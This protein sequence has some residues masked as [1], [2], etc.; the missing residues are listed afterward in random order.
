MLKEVQAI[1]YIRIIPLP[2]AGEGVLI[3]KG[4][5][6]TLE[7][8]TILGSQG[9]TISCLFYSDNKQ[10]AATRNLQIK[11][12]KLISGNDE[13]PIYKIQTNRMTG[14]PLAFLMKTL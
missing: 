2:T 5:D 10:E 4:N 14:N 6:I 12:N 3:N 11:G 9:A 7:G 1:L 8:N 13:Y